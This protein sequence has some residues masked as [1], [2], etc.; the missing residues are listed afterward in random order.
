[1][2]KFIIIFMSA[3]LF[4][5]VVYFGYLIYN[6]SSIASIEIVGD[7]QQ[8]YFVGDNINYADAKLKLVYKNGSEKTIAMQGNVEVSNFS[9]AGFGKYHGTMRIAYKSQTTEVDYVVIDRT[10]YKIES[11]R[12]ITN[13]TS[14][15]IISSQKRIIEFKENGICNF[16]KVK[17]GKY[18]KNDGAYD[19]TYNYKI[20]GDKI[21]VGLGSGLS[22][23]IKPEVSGNQIIIKAYTYYYT[24]SSQEFLSYKIETIFKES[25]EIKTNSQTQNKTEFQIYY[26]ECK[27]KRENNV[28]IFSKGQSI[29]DA[30]IYLIA[31]Y[32]NGEKY[33]VLITEAMLKNKLNDEHQVDTFFIRGYYQSR[34]LT[35]YYRFV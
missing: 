16:Y 29:E 20:V 26:D 10:A 7:M 30:N 22:Y 35:I 13:S 8:V 17:S 4:C 18:F 33:Y 6:S 1:M 3:I 27:V 32:D 24:D 2:K 28:L 19:Q 21:L 25:S 15:N 14:T 9:T 12:K 34:P 31:E 11:E 5:G 23:E